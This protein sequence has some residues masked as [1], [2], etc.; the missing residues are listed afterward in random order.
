MKTLKIKK[1][2]NR[3]ILLYK[4][5]KGKTRIPIDDLIL[6]NQLSRAFQTP[7]LLLQTSIN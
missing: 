7:G 6:K 3:F 1:K 4:R 5:L 2:D